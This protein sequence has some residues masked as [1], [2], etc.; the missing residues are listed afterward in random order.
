MGK[1]GGAVGF[2]LYLGEI[3][4]Y[5]SRDGDSVDYLILYDGKSRK[6]AIETAQKRLGEGHSVRLSTDVPA[7]VTV[8][9]IVDLTEK[10]S[11]G[12]KK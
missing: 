11:V 10:E 3:E 8:K 2:A 7:T 6:R 9:N 4:R 5:L 12:G 1:E